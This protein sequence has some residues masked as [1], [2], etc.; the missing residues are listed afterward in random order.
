MSGWVPDGTAQWQGRPVARRVADAAPRQ[1]A[2]VTGVV[3][4][5]FVQRRRPSHGRLHPG[6][7]GSALDAW[8]DDGSGTIT[9]R[10]LGRQALGGVVVGA[11][12]HVEGTVSQEAGRL[13]ILNPLYR[14]AAP[15]P[16]AEPA[17]EARSTPRPATEPATRSGE[18]GGTAVQA[19]SSTSW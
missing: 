2:V 7:R 19:E 18:D 16:P 5:V 15:G 13:L 4:A 9:L 17:V 11:A 3:R 14:F 12:M 8:L 6:G 10:W 1:R